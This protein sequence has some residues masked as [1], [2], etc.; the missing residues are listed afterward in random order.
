MR[1]LGTGTEFEFG[2]GPMCDDINTNIII[3]VFDNLPLKG[4]ETHTRKIQ[5][6]TF[7]ANRVLRPLPAVFA[8]IFAMLFVR[9]LYRY[10]EFG[11]FM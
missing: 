2:G 9:K 5:I 11:D 10:F 7:Y 4:D 3:Q 6:L 1:T 8:V